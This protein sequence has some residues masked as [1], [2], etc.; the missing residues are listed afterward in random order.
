MSDTIAKGEKNFVKNT[1]ADATDAT[2]VA[3]TDAA[4]DADHQSARSDASRM[5]RFSIAAPMFV[6]QADL[7]RKVLAWLEF[8]PHFVSPE[9]QPPRVDYMGHSPRFAALRQGDTVPE[10]WIRVKQCD[11]GMVFSVERQEEARIIVPGKGR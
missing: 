1:P 9:Q 7:V 4:P 5:G 10:Y 3:S 2:P 8:F 11:D 6:H